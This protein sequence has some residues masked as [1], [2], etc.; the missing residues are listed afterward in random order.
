ME[1]DR[2][3]DAIH[4]DDAE[5]RILHVQPYA[6]WTV[7]GAW[8]LFELVEHELKLIENIDPSVTPI[9][10]ERQQLMARKIYDS[11]RL[12]SMLVE[13]S[14]YAAEAMVDEAERYLDEQ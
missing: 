2:A 7:S 3:Q 8:K 11:A 4:L 14:P 10:A 9:H 5:R 6:E 13:L 12:R 1:F